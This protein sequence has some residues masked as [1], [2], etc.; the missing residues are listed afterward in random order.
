MSIDSELY[1]RLTNDAGISALV[2][3]KVYPV[4]LPQDVVLP[5][6]VYFKVSG[7]R[8]HHLGGASGR[9][10]ARFQIDSWAATPLAAKNLADAVRSSLGGFTGTLTAIKA[11][12]KLDNER[13]DYEDGILAYRVIQDY[14]INHTE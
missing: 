4:Q 7:P 14:I 1:T 10:H 13:D 2:S 5:A 6:I 12:I 11:S 3:A 8:L 9:A